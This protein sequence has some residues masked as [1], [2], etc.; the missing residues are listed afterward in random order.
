MPIHKKF[1]PRQELSTYAVC[2]PGKNSQILEVSGPHIFLLTERSKFGLGTIGAPSSK[3][4]FNFGSI[5]L[6]V[7]PKEISIAS[8]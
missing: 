8:H 2:P 3:L 6:V 5:Q 7:E 4:S 1:L